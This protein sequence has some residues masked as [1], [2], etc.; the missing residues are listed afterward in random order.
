MNKLSGNERWKSKMLL[1]EHQEQY[2][3]RNEPMIKGR[4][5]TDEVTMIRDYIMLPHM[6]TMTDRAYQDILRSSNIFKSYFAA[7]TQLIMDR[8]TSDL[9]S[10]RRDLR[11]RNI[12][13]VE[14]ET[15]DDIIYHKYYCRGYEDRFGI[16]REVLRSQISIRLAQYASEL[17]KKGESEKSKNE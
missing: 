1:T 14:S 3:S 7:M 4:P 12:K 8:I 6:L 11:S 15:Q 9:A 13:V 2:P 10:L 5:T 17:L 16:V